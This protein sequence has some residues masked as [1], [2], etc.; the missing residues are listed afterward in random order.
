MLREKMGRTATMNRG[1]M[2]GTGTILDGRRRIW[3]KLCSKMNICFLP[4]AFLRLLLAPRS[5]SPTVYEM[6]RKLTKMK[7]GSM[8]F[9]SVQAAPASSFAENMPGTMD[10]AP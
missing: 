2:P 3:Y 4:L 6:L 8:S 10:Q 5:S 7:M 9:A 1:R